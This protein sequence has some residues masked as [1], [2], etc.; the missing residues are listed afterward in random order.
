MKTFFGKVIHLLDPEILKMQEMG[1]CIPRYHVPFRSMIYLL[2]KEKF[3]FETDNGIKF[4]LKFKIYLGPEWN[5]EF[6]ILIRAPYKHFANFR[7][8]KG[9]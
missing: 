9:E 2:L 1:L 6:P 3:I 7:S 5:V 4:E 8:P